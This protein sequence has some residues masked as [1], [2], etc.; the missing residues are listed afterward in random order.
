MVR[1]LLVVPQF[2]AFQQMLFAQS[3]ESCRSTETKLQR[4]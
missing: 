4:Q 1:G 3:Q 2:Q